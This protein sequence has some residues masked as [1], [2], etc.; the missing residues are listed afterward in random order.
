MD[1]LIRDVKMGIGMRGIRFMEVG[2]EW[3]LPGLL[4]TDDLILC[5]KLVEDLRDMVG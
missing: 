5:V 4:Y 1:T 2:R 3:R